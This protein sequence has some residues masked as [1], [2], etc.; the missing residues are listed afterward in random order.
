MRNVGHLSLGC[1]FEKRILL[2]VARTVFLRPIS[3]CRSR[4]NSNFWLYT[5]QMRHPLIS[6]LS[7]IPLLVV[8]G[9]TLHNP[10]DSRNDRF[11]ASAAP[12]SSAAAA[13]LST[14]ACSAKVPSFARDSWLM[15]GGWLSAR[16]EVSG[17]KFLRGAES[18]PRREGWPLGRCRSAEPTSQ[19]RWS[20]GS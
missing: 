1:E 4:L 9:Q 3:R 8:R 20:F 6:G 12:R 10:R 11:C 16:V 15:R 13:S 17:P 18:Y 2:N 7:E 19:G 5:K 14:S